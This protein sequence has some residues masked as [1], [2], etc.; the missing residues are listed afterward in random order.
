VI[1]ASIVTVPI[2]PF[3]FIVA[4]VCAAAFAEEIFSMFRRLHGENQ[5]EGSGIGWRCAGS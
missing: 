5:Y 2:E 1:A 3:F 4:E